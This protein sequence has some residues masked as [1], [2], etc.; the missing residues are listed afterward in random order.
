MH[1]TKR[2]EVWDILDPVKD[3]EVQWVGVSVGIL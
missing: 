1:P 3:F 2:R